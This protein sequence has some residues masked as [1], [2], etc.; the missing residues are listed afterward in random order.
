MR[1]SVKKQVERRDESEK[2]MLEAGVILLA[3]RGFAGL[4]LTNVGKAAGYSRGLP[5]HHFGTKE[6]FEEKLFEFLA[7]KCIVFDSLPDEQTGLNGL[8]DTIA[9]FVD[10]C[11]GDPVYS[12]A[13]KISLSDT[14]EKLVISKPERADRMRRKREEVTEALERHIREAKKHGDIHERVDVNMIVLFLMATFSG[15]LA[16]WMS[17]PSV[18]LKACVKQL[19]FLVLHGLAAQP[20]ENAR[21]ELS[22]A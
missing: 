6:Q 14:W 9:A 20:R 16:E 2:R 1:K 10:R 22:V 8:L 13:L 21:I 12:A 7:D 3:E 19:N 4:T 5:A 15:I 11:A 17:N 18:D